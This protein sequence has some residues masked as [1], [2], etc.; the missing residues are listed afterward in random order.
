MLSCGNPLCKLDSLHRQRI[1]IASHHVV[2]QVGLIMDEVVKKKEGH[3]RIAGL[4]INVSNPWR[5]CRGSSATWTGAVIPVL[6]SH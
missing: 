6:T 4:G 3:G 2:S 5:S 1:L